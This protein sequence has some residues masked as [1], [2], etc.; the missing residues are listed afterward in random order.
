MEDAL[1][2]STFIINKADEN[3]ATLRLIGGLAFRQHC[4]EIDFCERDYGDIDLVGLSD[5][6]S[7][8]IKT[9][10]DLDYKE[11][12]RYTLV[13]GGTRLLFEK[14]GSSDHVDIFLD[15]LRMEHDI[16]LRLRLGFEKLTISVSDL[17]VC[18]LIILRFNEKDYRDIITIVKDLDVG[19]EDLP[20]VINMNYVGELC[21]RNW[22]LYQDVTSSI[23]D[24]IKFIENYQLDEETAQKV[25]L[26]FNL[27]RTA[28]VNHP[29]SLRWKFRSLIGERYPWRKK[30]E[31]ER[32]KR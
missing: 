32:I 8:I 17:L 29:K 18:K 22:G 15:K 21:S 26:K 27:I 1:Q 2:K 6:S 19:Y 25:A 16:D 3:G 10:N 28:I 11:N 24:C 30:V 13:S 23:D 14:F 12:T 7:I 5:E 20:S 4:S 31:L 9:L